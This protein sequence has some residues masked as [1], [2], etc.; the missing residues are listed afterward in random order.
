MKINS[1]FL[2]LV[3]IVI[4]FLTG[5]TII[6]NL[7]YDKSNNLPRYSSLRADP[8]GTKIIFESLS[9]LSDL[10]VQRNFKS[11]YQLPTNYKYTFFFLGSTVDSFFNNINKN[12][13]EKLHGLLEKGNR[14]V[15]ALTPDKNSYSAR[16]TRKGEEGEKEKVV[17]E[18]DEVKDEGI[19]ESKDFLKKNWDICFSETS[20][21]SQDN[22]KKL[23]LSI[24][25]DSCNIP[26]NSNIHF[27]IGEEWSTI[28]KDNNKNLI[29][30][31][32]VGNGS[33]VFLSDS[34]LLSNEAMFND[35]YSWFLSWLIGNNKNIIFDEVHL[36]IAHKTKVIELA[37]RYKLHGFFFGLIILAV[38]YIWKNFSFFIPNEQSSKEKKNITL[39]KDTSAGFVQLLERSISKEDISKICKNEWLKTDSVKRDLSQ[40]KL[41]RIN[42][43]IELEGNLPGKERNPIKTYSKIRKIILERREYGE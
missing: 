22:H 31:R 11:Y 39:G 14:L 23:L 13:F 37:K 8:L 26:W 28:L 2:G 5:I 25:P 32:A 10:N 24:V 18:D 42:A 33:L 29:V 6:F 17:D 27:E 15:F 43:V 30:E 34:Y 19:K 36:G 7:Q 16:K 1:V 35:R 20:D 38:L 21:K 12:D 41:D 4:L 9:N 3:I 40:G